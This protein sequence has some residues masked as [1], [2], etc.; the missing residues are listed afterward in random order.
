MAQNVILNTRLTHD[1]LFQIEAR[2][3]NR[4]VATIV[5]MLDFRDIVFSF[6]KLCNHTLNI[7]PCYTR[8]IY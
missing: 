2:M 7:F 1:F 5:N 6:F 3:K 4:I 8:E